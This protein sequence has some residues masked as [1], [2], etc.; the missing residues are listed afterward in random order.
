MVKYHIPLISMALLLK[1]I[2]YCNII[3]RRL[4][5][6]KLLSSCEC[7]CIVY[8]MCIHIYNLYLNYVSC[9]LMTPVCV[10]G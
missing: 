6:K 5:S 7:E 10:R 8:D 9:E 1:R 2:Y 3:K 4:A